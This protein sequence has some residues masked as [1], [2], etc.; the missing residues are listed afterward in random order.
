MNRFGSRTVFFS[1]SH[2]AAVN[3]AV[4]EFLLDRIPEGEEILF[5]CENSPAVVIGRFQNPWKECRTGLAEQ[6]GIPVYRRISGGGTVV[7]DRGN[8][9]FSVISGSRTPTK[10]T[11]L[12]RVI[13]AVGRLGVRLFRNDRFDLRINLSGTGGTPADVDDADGSSQ[14][15]GLSEPF[16]SQAATAGLKVSGS[17]FRQV[18]AAS[19][20]HATL[21]VDSNL[22]FLRELLKQPPRDMVVKGVSSVPSPVG[23][24]SGALPG[25]KVEHVVQALSEEW[26]EPYAILETGNLAKDDFFREAL[27]RLRSR[28]WRLEKT[29]EFSE[30]FSGIPGYPEPSLTL[31]VSAGRVSM[32]PGPA[33]FLLGADYRGESFFAAAAAGGDMPPWLAELSRRVDGD[34]PAGE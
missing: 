13:R 3:L 24:I 10:E 25:L 1:D 17:A 11:N 18:S 2:D 16:V 34:G 23:N 20:H 30:T 22:D 31:Q 9:N 29:P 32:A 5:L 33:A 4:E 27:K 26:G 21:L 12:D 8:L 15:R 14:S 6:R 28:E 7:H 19:M